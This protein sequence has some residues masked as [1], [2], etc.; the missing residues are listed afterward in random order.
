MNE[1]GLNFFEPGDAK[2]IMKILKRPEY[3]V[4]RTVADKVI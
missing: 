4:F 3:A 2:E 1:T